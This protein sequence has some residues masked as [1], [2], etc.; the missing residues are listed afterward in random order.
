MTLVTQNISDQFSAHYNNKTTVE[1]S[2]L[3]RILR[4]LDEGIGLKLDNVLEALVNDTNCKSVAKTMTSIF[5]IGAK[6]LFKDEVAAVFSKY[7]NISSAHAETLQPP[8]TD[9]RTP[10]DVQVKQMQSDLTGI[11]LALNVL[12]WN[13]GAKLEDLARDEHQHSK[14]GEGVINVVG[15]LGKTRARLITSDDSF[16]LTPEM[17]QDIIPLLQGKIFSKDSLGIDV[18]NNI[19]RFVSGWSFTPTQMRVG[20]AERL[21]AEGMSVPEVAEIQG[22]REGTLRNRLKDYRNA[23]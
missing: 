17:V 4:H 7:V 20:H 22:V 5:S 9:R 2:V 21:I 16:G 18:E 11:S 15:V 1:R 3:N 19:R 12:L 8:V 6:I 13:S 10:N 14:V 23:N